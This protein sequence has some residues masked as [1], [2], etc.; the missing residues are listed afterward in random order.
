MG[1]L[2]SLSRTGSILRKIRTF[3]DML[4]VAVKSFFAIPEYSEVAANP[5]ARTHTDVR[6]RTFVASAATV[7]GEM[8][9]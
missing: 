7:I 8:Y 6:E 2:A 5:M 9:T 4:L 3:S 1:E